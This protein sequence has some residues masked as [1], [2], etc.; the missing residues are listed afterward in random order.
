MTSQIFRLFGGAALVGGGSC[1]LGLKLYG[2]ISLHKVEGPSMRPTLNPSDS[3]FRD[4]V[5]VKKIENPADVQFIPV[6]SIICLKHPKQDRGYLIKRLIANQN[7]EIRKD[8][9]LLTNSKC[10][11]NKVPG[12]HCWVES[13]AGPGYL[14]SS[15]YLGPIS[16]NNVVG[17]A[18]FNVWPLHRIKRL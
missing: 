11:N 9:E 17:H 12:G 10:M 14:D 3:F 16:Y 13:D 6:S 5:L 2:N 7:E 15:S 1:Y 18:L 8:A 4:I